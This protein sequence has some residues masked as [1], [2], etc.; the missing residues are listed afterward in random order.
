MNKLRMV[1]LVVTPIVAVLVLMLGLRVGAR[2]AVRAA[3]VWGAPPSRGRP[4]ANLQVLTF[5]DDRGV[6]EA[7]LVPKVRVAVT[8]VATG[9]TSELSADTNADGVLE[10]AVP[11]SSMTSSELRVI[12]TAPSEAGPLAEGTVTLPKGPFGPRDRRA[13]ATRAT[14]RTGALVVDLFVT[15][16]RLV[17]G[18][19]V[20]TV[21]RVT[22]A[23]GHAVEGVELSVVPEPGLDSEPFTKTCSSGYA[24]GNLKALFHTVGLTISAKTPDGKEGSL[25]AALP[26]AQGAYY[27]DAAREVEPNKPFPVTVRAPGERSVAYAEIDDSEGRAFAT[28]LA[29]TREPLGPSAAFLSPGLPEGLYWIVTS[30]DPRGASRIEGSTVARALRVRQGGGGVTSAG[31]SFGSSACDDRADLAM[32]PGDGFVRSELLDGL[33]QRRRDDTRREH[34]GLVIALVGLLAAA[35]IEILIALQI[36]HDARA[37]IEGAVREAEGDLAASR[38][39]KRTSAGSV[40][41]GIAIG[42]LGFALL[43]ALLVWKT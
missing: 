2:G 23:S 39:T 3:T 8:E 24:F 15:D 14:K 7:V 26:V 12:V 9:K 13:A 28:T 38:V 27:V 19:P 34:F 42:V 21:V 40:I 16:E 30:G 1:V 36:V 31:A 18:Y 33:P 41:V 11:L 5:L 25:F 4:I 29:L 35:V 22:D 6:R 20:P 17:V 43:A 32:H 10:V 37:T